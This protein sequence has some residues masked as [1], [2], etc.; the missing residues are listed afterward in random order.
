MKW[1]YSIIEFEDGT[2]LPQREKTLDEYFIEA[3][4]VYTRTQILS[5]RSLTWIEQD[6]STILYERYS[7]IKSATENIKLSLKKDTIVKVHPVEV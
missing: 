5:I 6:K 3:R 4:V 1:V 7:S 2:F